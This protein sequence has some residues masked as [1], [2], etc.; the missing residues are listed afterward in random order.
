[1]ISHQELIAIQVTWH[2]D[3]I[4]EY[5]VAEIYNEI[6][7][8][9]LNL[10]QYNENLKKEKEL[11]MESCGDKDNFTLINNLLKAQRNKTLL[12][13]KQGLQN[14]LENVLEE[15]LYPTLTHEYKKDNT[16]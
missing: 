9:K 2:R 11:L 4:F 5:N 13:K 14:D 12:V 1:M 3:F 16:K 15:H 6:F 10:D 8:R 7:G